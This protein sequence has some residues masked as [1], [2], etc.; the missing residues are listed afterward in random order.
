[1][2]GLLCTGG[3]D[4][5]TKDSGGRAQP[6]IEN[7]TLPEQ[8]TAT[9]EGGG[10]P[11]PPP[12][13]EAEPEPKSPRSASSQDPLAKLRDPEPDPG[14]IDPWSVID[15]EAM[16][17]RWEGAWVIPGAEGVR[18]GGW[19]TSQILKRKGPAFELW[20]APWESE[21][22]SFEAELP[23]DLVVAPANGPKTGLRA[24]V[25]PTTG[26]HPLSNAG[27]V[28][29]RKGE[30]AVV[31]L[32]PMMGVLTVDGDDCKWWKRPHP[33]WRAGDSQ[34]CRWSGDLLEVEWTETFMETSRTRRFVLQTRDGDILVPEKT[35]PHDSEMRR[36][37]SVKAA[38]KFLCGRKPGNCK[39]P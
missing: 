25:G 1:M 20:H 7:V 10:V 39:R 9:V 19:G 26:Y 18:P 6:R 32:P 24:V 16:L 30:R 22:R 15:R 14:A 4:A 29:Y 23:C 11:G 17:E 13:V 28:G 36:F 12:A 27:A 2:A 21:T 5:N 3:C 8:A 35:D 31:C 34:V 33:P 37:A 38:E